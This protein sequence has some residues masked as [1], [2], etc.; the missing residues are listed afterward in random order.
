MSRLIQ[1]IEHLER[2]KVQAQNAKRV[3]AEVL[4]ALTQF[5]DDEN[6]LTVILVDLITLRKSLD[7]VLNEEES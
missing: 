7:A 4:P 1:E 5:E 6:R 3:L 2:V